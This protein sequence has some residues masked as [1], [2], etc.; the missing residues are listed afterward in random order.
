[1]KGKLMAD[2]IV[3]VGGGFAGFWAAVAARR[4]GGS[5]IAIKLISPEPSL[6][7]RPRLYEANPHQLS[8]DLVPLLALLDIEFVRGSAVDLQADSRALLLDSGTSLHYDRL[9]V[10][11]GS[12]MSR[13]A[14]PGAEEAYSIDCQAD[15]VVFDRRLAEMALHNGEQSI[16]VVGAGFTG[17]ELALEL[18]D[19]LNVHGGNG[20]ALRVVLIDRSPVVG[21]ELGAGPRAT[22]EAAL[23]AAGV[24]RRL[25]ESIA[26][27]EAGRIGFADGGSLDVDAV[28][29]NTGLTAAPFVARVPGQRDRVGRIVVE[30]D[31][32][33]PDARDVFV[34]GDA[35]AADTG[36]GRLT[37]QSCQHALQ[38]GRFAGE[39]AVRDLLG[40]PTVEYVQARYVTCLDLGRSGAVFTTGW[41]REVTITGDEAKAIKRKINSEIIYPRT[42][43]SAE[44]L[45]AD[46]ELPTS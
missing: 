15:A 33:A 9:V 19:R 28:V 44:E 14:I 1:V 42:D 24:Q 22:I 45:L 4:V 37:L 7:I 35:A 2:G 21:N 6:V 46:S 29:L 16:A 3:V 26:S 18:P 27:V 32:R 17:I 23:D 11:V 30:R 20:D 31:L 13:P 39:N 38:L 8:V 12:V 25:G 41:D 40:L 43:A 5:T 10:A 34:A 36:A